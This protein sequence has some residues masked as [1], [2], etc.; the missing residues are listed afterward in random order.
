VVR[1]YAVALVLLALVPAVAE[2]EETR[3]SPAVQRLLDAKK[4]L[5]WNAARPGTTERYGHAEALV[6]A[7]PDAVRRVALDF[8]HYHELNRKFTGARVVAKKDGVT[9]VYMKL[10]VKIGPFTLDQWEIM[11]FGPDAAAPGGGFVIEGR[12]IQGSMKQGHLVI[13][14]TPVGE[15]HTLLAIDLLLVPR[16]YAPRS[17]VEEELRDGALD[18]VNGMKTRAQGWVGPVVAL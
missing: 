15:R 11:R 5:H 10:P 7:T 8:E 13:T 14:V 12:G 3:V 1:P 17:M 6:A 16:F 2:A 4:A 9:D 18:L